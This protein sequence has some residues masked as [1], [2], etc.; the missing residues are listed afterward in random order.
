MH[1]RRLHPAVQTCRRTG[2]AGD[3]SLRTFSILATG[4]ALWVLYGVLQKDAVIILA[5]SVSLT[6]LA[7]ILYF[8]LRE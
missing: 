1:V 8:K 3:L 2:W 4:I 5:N 6:F 7:F